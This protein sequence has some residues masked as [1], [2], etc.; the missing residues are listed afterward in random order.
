MR[1]LDQLRKNS[2]KPVFDI[3]LDSSLPVGGQL[4]IN[5]I[6]TKVTGQTRPSVKKPLWKSRGTLVT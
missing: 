4:T 5:L 3:P 6:G 2:G 1:K